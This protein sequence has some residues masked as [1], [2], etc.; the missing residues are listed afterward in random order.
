MLEKLFPNLNGQLDQLKQ[1]FTVTAFSQIAL[2]VLV[3]GL[4]TRSYNIVKR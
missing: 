2:T 4:F 3:F 1:Y